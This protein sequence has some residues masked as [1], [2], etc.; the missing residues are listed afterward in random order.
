MSPSSSFARK[1]V[2]LDRDGVLNRAVMKNGRPYPPASIEELE[3]DSDA[4]HACA[5]FRRAGFVLVLVTNQPDIARGKQ[6]RKTVDGLNALVREQLQLDDVRICPHDDRDACT[7][8]KPLPG[9]LVDAAA[10][11]GID[12]ANSFMV[13]DRWRDIEAGN[14][15]GCQTV[16]I[17]RG[18][19]EAPP[20]AQTFTAV[21]L[22]QAARWILNPI[23]EKELTRAGAGSIQS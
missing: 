10:D 18:Y 7:C 14:R 4:Q 6:D 3:L 2:F 1:A 9:M 12:L 21:T 23:K 20:S 11:W 13:G 19:N 8:R 15:A 16:F 22:H 17:E 5:D